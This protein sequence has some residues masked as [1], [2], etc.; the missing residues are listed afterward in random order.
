MPTVSAS[1]STKPRSLLASCTPAP[2][3]SS[4]NKTA[5]TKRAAAVTTQAN[6]KGGRQWSYA[7]GKSSVLVAMPVT[8]CLEYGSLRAYGCHHELNEGTHLG[9]RQVA[10]R[11]QRVER[12]AVVGPVREQ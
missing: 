9:R 3:Q 5:G 6:A 11:I 7:S 10:R 4:R 1:P 8:L 2:H 12:Q